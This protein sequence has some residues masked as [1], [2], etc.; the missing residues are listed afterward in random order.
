MV[1]A[2]LLTLAAIS[3]WFFDADTAALLK[4]RFG[5][6]LHLWARATTDVAVAGPY[7]G[8]AG[9]LFVLF[10]LQFRVTRNEKWRRAR[11]WALF[12]F[13]SFAT[14]GILVQFLKH[15]IGRK[16]PYADAALSSHEF[17]P[18]TANYEFHSLPSGHSQVLFSAASVLSVIWPRV[19]WLWMSAAAIFSTT[20]VI[21]L[22]HWASDV[23]AGA[24][25]GMFGTVLTLRLFEYRKSMR[26]AKAFAVLLGIGFVGSAAHA[27]TAGPFG[28]GLV[29]GNPTGLSA[30]YRFGADRSVDGALAWNFG[31]YSGF[32]IH[33]DYLWHRKNIIRGKFA[34]DLHYGI[35][36]R[37]VSR[38]DRDRDI[39][40]NDRTY[41]GPRIPVGIGTNFNQAA[42]EVFG[43]VALVMNLIPGTS[44]D[45]D[46][47]VGA[48]IYF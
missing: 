13:L 15:L 42:L 45:L 26:V 31:R 19:W 33:S 17:S 48:R 36:G 40:N 25:V 1:C 28:L 14:G 39:N 12:A 43:E 22:N 32:E 41:L 3:I 38:G 35:G 46:F 5:N 6:P 30:N 16:R 20:R 11:H 34:F 27:D 8:I 7:F 47:G 18:F 37:L 2:P 44:A 24:A 4:P 9:A 10:W 21:T 23:L 29:L